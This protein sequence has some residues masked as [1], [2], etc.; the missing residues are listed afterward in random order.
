MVHQEMFAPALDEYT[1]ELSRLLDF[2]PDE[3]HECPPLPSERCVILIGYNFPEP[4]YV[5]AFTFGVSFFDNPEWKLSRPEFGICLKS[6]NNWWRSLCLLNQKFRHSTFEQGTVLDVGSAV[7]TDCDMNAFL[8]APFL[9]SEAP[10]TEM[11]LPHSRVNLSQLVPVKLAEA[12][13]IRRI[14]I[15]EFLEILGPRVYE[16]DRLRFVM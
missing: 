15:A 12:D 1:A 11:E 3:I 2:Q 9:L 5:T 13:V 7:A 16:P 8:I 10:M 14:G 6:S 4:G